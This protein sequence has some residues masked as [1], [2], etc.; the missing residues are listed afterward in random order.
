[1]TEGSCTLLRL[2][3]IFAIH[4]EWISYLFCRLKTVFVK[5]QSLSNGINV[6]DSQEDR[7]LK[8]HV[9]KSLM[10][11]FWTASGFFWSV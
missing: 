3:A 2:P 10:F 1:M 7:N 5:V 11:F 4:A 9:F 6:L 8:N